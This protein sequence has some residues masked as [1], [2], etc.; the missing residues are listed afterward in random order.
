[1]AWAGRFLLDLYETRRRVWNLLPCVV[2]LPTGEIPAALGKLHQLQELQLLNNK[3]SGE[4]NDGRGARV[5]F[6]FVC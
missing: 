1:M 4:S 2:V 3:L 6:Y 5:S